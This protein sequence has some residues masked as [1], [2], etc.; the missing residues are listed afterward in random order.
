MQERHLYEYAVIRIVPRVEREEF[1]NAGIILFCK[2]Q[3]Y[4]RC[5][6]EINEQKILALFAGADIAVIRANLEAF[7][8]IALGKKS[9]SPISK[10]D[11]PDRFRW[12]TATRST[13][14]QTGKIHPGL[15]GDCDAVF[16]KL[17]S[18]LVL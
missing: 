6:F 14:I 1:V 18:A 5:R 8:A 4:L 16:E 15:T 17:F 12:L 11:V 3:K 10:L 7:E 2:K 13:I 9:K